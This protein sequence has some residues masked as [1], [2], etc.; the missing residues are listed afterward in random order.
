MTIE[1]IN[2]YL[3]L[4]EELGK[5]DISTQEVDKLLI[6]L[7]NARECEFD[8]KKI[9]RKKQNSLKNSCE[10]LSKQL[11]EYKELLH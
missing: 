8:S 7:G 11:Q 10:M 1:A 9:V 3:K 4:K 6:L 2:E 5:Y